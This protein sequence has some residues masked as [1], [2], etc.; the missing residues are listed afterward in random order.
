MPPFF[1]TTDGHVG[2]SNSQDGCDAST[3]SSSNQG[4]FAANNA[5][6]AAPAGVV[7][8]NGVFGISTV[9]NASGVLGSN[10][11]GGAGVTGTSTGGVG[12]TGTSEG[13][14]GMV[15][16]TN[17]S[18]NQGIFAA[19]N[20]TDAAP[21]GVVGGN[22]VFGIS[23]VPNA[24]GVLGSNNS[25]GAGVTG[26]STGG[27]GVTGTSEGGSGMLASTNSSSNQ[28]IFAANNA[29]HAAPAGVIGGNGVFGISTVPNASGVLGSNNSGGAGVTGTSTGG[30]GVT[31]ASEGGSGMLASTNSSSNQGIFAANNAT[32][33][34]PAGV[35]GGN[36]VFGISTVPNASGVL[37]SN[38]SGGAG[39]TGTS[40]NGVGVTGIGPIAGHFFGNVVV[41]GDITLP[42]GSDF[43]EDFD[44]HGSDQVEPGTVMV[45]D[46]TGGLTPS[47]RAYDKRVAG[48]ISGA[49]EFRAGVI[50][51]RQEMKTN[52]LPVA[53]VG[54]VFCKV[55]ADV[56]PIEVGDLLSSSDTPGYAM[57][58]ADAF[59]TFGSVI[60]KALRPLA[61]GRGLIPI[62]VS[63]Q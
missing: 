28:G 25:G 16:A 31:G 14:S 20:A 61:A 42:G 57:K 3:T 33:A 34:A 44:I 60:G 15:A 4:I 6:D 56:S 41:T 8:G 32:D 63:L 1:G 22:G 40:A 23:T 59:Q 24:S 39:V 38:N 29:T 54:R 13:G 30:V 53:L 26:T 2:N 21:A 47:S 50:L 18:S 45:I 5:T 37:G 36:G 9:P 10:N 43:A 62:L 17:S 35:I 11:N 55:D 52:R 49:G 46:D 51:G 27:V 7:G 19:N 12:V 58:A 48:V